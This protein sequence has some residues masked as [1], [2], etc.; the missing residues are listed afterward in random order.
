MVSEYTQK[1]SADL[2]RFLKW[3]DETGCRKTIATPDGQ[4]AI[5]ILTVHKSKG[6]GFKV[7]II[8]FGDWEI[9][10][11]P[12]KP[13]ILWCHPEEKPFDRLHL[14]PVRYGQSLGKTIFAGDYLRNDCMPLLTT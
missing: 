9:D 1:E 13:V 14:V 12:T 6:L 3:W 11:K 5:R 7:V 2:N 4:N 10:H 8:P